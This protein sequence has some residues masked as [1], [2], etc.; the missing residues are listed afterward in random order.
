MEMG[1]APPVLL[2]ISW[3]KPAGVLKGL[4]MLG[5]ALLGERVTWD[6][7]FSPFRPL[8]LV[9]GR[10]P[11]C[12]SAPPAPTLPCSCLSRPGRELVGARCCKKA[13]FFLCPPNVQSGPGCATGGGGQQLTRS[14]YTALGS[15]ASCELGTE[16]SVAEFKLQVFK[17]NYWRQPVSDELRFH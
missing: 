16:L 1:D 10:A 7:P 4:C 9:T 5:L 12:V 2:A 17:A 3:R 14:C 13:G 8:L 15:G 6:S 11:S